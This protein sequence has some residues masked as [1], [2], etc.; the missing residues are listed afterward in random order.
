MTSMNGVKTATKEADF[1]EF[2]EEMT[3][4]PESQGTTFRFIKKSK[5]ASFSEIGNLPGT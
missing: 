3:D 2:E 5:H 1:G 4:M